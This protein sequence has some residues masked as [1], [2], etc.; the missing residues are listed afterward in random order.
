[1]THLRDY[2]QESKNDVYVAWQTH[3]AVMLVS[4][5]GSGKTV[6]FSDII[7]EYRGASVAIAHRQELVSQ[8]S[9]A[10]ARCGVRHA[11]IAPKAV[12]KNIVSIHMEELGRSYYDPT[13]RVRVAGV[14]TLIK[15]DLNEPWL[16][17]VGLVIMD[18]GHHVLRANKWGKAVALFPHAKVLLVTATPCR[19]DGKG[20]G[21]SSAGV[22]DVLVLGPA[23][24]TL[25]DRGYLTPFRIFAPPVADLNL[26]NVGTTA[27]GEFSPEPLRAA[28]HASSSIVGDVVTH[29]LK[30]AAGMLGVTF[31]VDIEAA[32]ELAAEYRRKGVPAEIVT[33][34][35][36]DHLRISILRRFKR[37]EILQLVNVDLFGEGFDLPAI[38]VV[39]F[40]R[41]T[42]SYA[43]F[44]QQ[45]GRALRLMV[46]KELADQWDTFTDD[47]RRAH[48]A[49]SGK[50]FA[51]ILDHVG[52]I[53]RHYGAPTAP[54]EWTLDGT[55]AQLHSGI[56]PVRT[57]VK[58]T[59][60]FERFYKRCPY[61][62]FYPE[63]PARTAPHF[64][65]GELGELTPEAL[66][67][68]AKEIRAIDYTVTATDARSGAIRAAQLERQRA[69]QELRYALSLWGGWRG[70]HGESIGQA[71]RRFFH[72][73]GVDV[74]TA[75]TL[76]AK[77][78]TE[79]REQVCRSWQ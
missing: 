30:H 46:S 2:Q 3:S 60:V 8:M 54:R 17:Q 49:A 57:C 76:S 40:A 9:L 51:I 22:A 12:I 14:D 21:S 16:Q 15:I 71:Q 56:I 79:L 75:Q 48:I 23:M 19:A 26:Q 67:A 74:G 45:F 25:L 13:S 53:E 7:S 73:F 33:A 78:A 47:E 50:P 4:P 39:S 77:E 20:L 70:H 69:Q 43:L 1:M 32:A 58:C 44:V 41:P 18:E 28:V 72:T 62:G 31:A 63:P 36:P 10:L 27:G 34:N 29:Y 66:A 64:V 11:I 68:M 24:Q 52:N 38:E 5:T 61:C 55:K 65:D 35:T 6:L 59:Q 37:R 42:Q